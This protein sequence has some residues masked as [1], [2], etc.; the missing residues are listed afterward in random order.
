[1]KHVEL[2]LVRDLVLSFMRVVLMCLHNL[3]VVPES[4]VSKQA[5][6]PQQ[7]HQPEQLGGITQW[8]PEEGGFPE[9]FGDAFNTS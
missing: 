2:H 9:T 3:L 4:M 7:L 8:H 6:V 5:E 1:M